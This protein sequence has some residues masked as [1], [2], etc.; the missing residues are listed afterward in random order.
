MFWCSF[1]VF[2]ILLL[3]Y[4]LFVYEKTLFY[5]LSILFQNGQITQERILVLFFFCSDVAILAIRQ[6]A[7]ALVEQLT[8]WSLEFIKKQVKKQPDIF[9]Q[10]PSLYYVSKGLGGWVYKIASFADV[11]HCIYADLTF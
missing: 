8:R 5:F 9:C 6:G 3:L 11:H 4:N 7:T 10:G 1:C 2:L